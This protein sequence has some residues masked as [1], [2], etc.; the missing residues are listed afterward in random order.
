MR[1]EEVLKEERERGSTKAQIVTRLKR[2]CGL[3]LAEAKALIKTPAA[4]DFES[5][6][7][8]LAFLREELAYCG[9]SYYEEAL[10]DL[11]A[12]LDWADSEQRAE[13]PGS[14]EN[15]GF[16]VWFLYLLDQRDFIDH[17]Q[18]VADAV[19]TEKGRK[20]LKSLHRFFKES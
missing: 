20:F 2:E 17:G 10:L 6:E 12:T 13:L 9:C 14:S 8:L 1:P 18:N 5:R 7:Q 16:V 4:A 15:V 19:I 3:S 11:R